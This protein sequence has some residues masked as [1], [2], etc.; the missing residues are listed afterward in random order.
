M[1]TPAHSQGTLYATYMR[2]WAAGATSKA[3]DPLFTQ[4]ADQDIRDEYAKGYGDGRADRSTASQ[5][6]S[7][8]S[9]YTPRILRIAD[10]ET[11]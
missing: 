7:A 4:H 10:G 11:P 2:G 5:V 1:T 3:M 9:G 8:R 6:A